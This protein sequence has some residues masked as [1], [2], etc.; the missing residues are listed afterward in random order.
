MHLGPAPDKDLAFV[1]FASA[2][3]DLFEA[4]SLVDRRASLISRIDLPQS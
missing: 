1:L 2:L 3:P 4:T